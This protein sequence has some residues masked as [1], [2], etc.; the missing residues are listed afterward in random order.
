M[1]LY[2]SQLLLESGKPDDALR[3]LQSFEQHICDL[4]T[5][6]ETKGR[7]SLGSR[8]RERERAVVV[9]CVCG[10]ADD[11]QIRSPD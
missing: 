1:I 3:H 2:E 7:W 6:W 4:L 5:Y 9:D 8:E 11:V 10:A